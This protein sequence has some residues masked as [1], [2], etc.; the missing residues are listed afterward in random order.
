MQNNKTEESRKKIAAMLDKLSRGV[1]VVEGKHD[2][3][4]FM[5]L[6]ISAIS[7]DRLMRNHI[8]IE[9]GKIVYLIMD[10]DNG[11]YDKESKALSFLIERNCNVNTELGHYL[12]KLLN[13]TSVEQAYQP[14]MD[15]L[16]K[17]NV[18]RK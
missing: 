18:K 14:I 10:N 13:I 7:Y 12:L 5:K 15:V 17:E 2:I 3:D 9:E 11:G 6:G 4:M 8:D 1:V 16:K